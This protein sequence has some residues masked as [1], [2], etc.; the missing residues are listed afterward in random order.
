MARTFDWSRDCA[1]DVG[2]PFPPVIGPGRGIV[3]NTTISLRDTLL[4]LQGRDGEVDPKAL[5][6]LNSG[7]A[8]RYPLDNPQERK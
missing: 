1:P 3:M 5:R 8:R 7:Q 6:A 2:R 4:W